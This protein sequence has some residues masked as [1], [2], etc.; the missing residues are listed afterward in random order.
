MKKH[1]FLLLLSFISLHI[2]SQNS[3]K[4]AWVDSVYNSLNDNER[5]GQLLMLRANQSRKPY[6]PKINQYIKDYAIGGVCFF[7]AGPQQQLSQMNKWQRL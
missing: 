2:F 4:E 3:L 5:F 7:A 1:I 6:N